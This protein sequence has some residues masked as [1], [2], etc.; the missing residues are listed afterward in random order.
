MVITNRQFLGRGQRGN[1][2]ET[3]DGANL[4]FSI[5]LYPKFLTPVTQFMLS[6]AVSLA[7]VDTLTSLGIP[8][9][10]IKWPNDIIILGR[11]ICGILIESSV[12]GAE[13]S[14]SVVGIGL[15]VNQVVFKTPNATS[16]AQATGRRH[17]LNDVL[18]SL[19]TL[20]EGRYLQ[21]RNNPGSLSKSYLDLLYWRNAPH[22]FETAGKTFFGTIEDVDESGRLCVSSSG[23]LVRFGIKE[24][25]YIK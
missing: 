18:A 25:A 1:T 9:A 8:D 23:N 11:K 24:I 4:T 19:L 3:E 10:M 12:R 21:L 2:W 6:K 13:L 14:Q 15:N 22:M 20:I 7:V 17:D 16:L 5:I